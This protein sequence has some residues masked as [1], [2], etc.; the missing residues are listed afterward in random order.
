MALITWGDNY[1]VKIAGIDAQHQK[2]V[3][4]I[5]ELH[6]AMRMAKGNEILGKII[7]E[8]VDYTVFHFSFEEKLM[9]EAKYPG[10][11]KHRIE[12]DSLKTKVRKIKS[13]F[14]SGKTVISIEV[15]QF[16]KDW[17]VN[18]IMHSDKEYSPFL[19]KKAAV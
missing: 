9:S 4:L 2:L 14:D 10:L 5:N 7:T 19:V 11:A 6:D 8:L 12:H 17:L 15:M 1:S 3:K 16:L 13:D 18:H